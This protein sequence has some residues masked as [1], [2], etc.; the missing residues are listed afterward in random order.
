[1]YKWSGQY[2]GQGWNKVYMHMYVAINNGKPLDSV[3]IELIL[4]NYQHRENQCSH[5]YINSDIPLSFLL[6][7]D[8]QFE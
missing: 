5:G 8:L 1:M 7:Y 6:I 3:V 2:W 4:R